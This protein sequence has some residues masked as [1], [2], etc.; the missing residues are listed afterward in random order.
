MFEKL[1]T[2]KVPKSRGPLRCCVQENRSLRGK[3][4]LALGTGCAR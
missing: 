1:H 4:L 3:N 2:E